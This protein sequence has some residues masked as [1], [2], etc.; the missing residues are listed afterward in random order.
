MDFNVEKI[1][2]VHVDA[3]E[4]L[5]DRDWMSPYVWLEDDTYCLLVR[6]V[7]KH[8]QAT[9]NTGAIFLGTGADGITFKLEDTPV[10]APGPGP[11][12]IG[13]CEDPTIVKWKDEFTVYYTGVDDSRRS[14]QM[15]YASG[16]DLRRLTKRGIAYASSKTQGNTKE[17][18]IERTADNRWRLF[19][20]YAHE[21]A[22]LIGLALGD[23]VA[24]PWKEQPAPFHP[25]TERWDNWHLSTGPL[26][27]SDPDMPVMFYNGA[28]ID[29]RWRIGW[30]AFNRDC[31]VVVDRCIEPLIVPPPPLE[32]DATDI[33]FAASIVI[34]AGK[35]FLYYSLADKAL[36]RAEIRGS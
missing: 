3:P 36:F 21:D 1:E 18:T 28:T 30:A 16:R 31:T 29:A 32:R 17:A 13:G 19:Y 20:E 24:G 25:R 23:G 12:D 33:A 15:L 10:I 11:L 26:L 9:G 14:G 35:T 34:V 7:P 5:K 27:T 8:L 2:A 6:A 4:L 22:S